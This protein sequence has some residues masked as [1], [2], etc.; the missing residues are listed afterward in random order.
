MRER[1]FGRVGLIICRPPEK[2]QGAKRIPEG[3]DDL[4]L[5]ASL[6]GTGRYEIGISQMAQALADRIRG[7]HDQVLQGDHMGRPR[8]HSAIM[9]HLDHPRCLYPAI[10]LLRDATLIQVAQGIPCGPQGICAIGL[11]LPGS[12]TLPLGATDLRYGISLACEMR[13]EP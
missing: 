9:G 11:G 6:A 10:P 3:L 2:G 13:T 5:T 8:L 7:G 1:I 4:F 12:A